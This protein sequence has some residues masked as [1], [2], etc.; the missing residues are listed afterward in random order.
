ME[1]IFIKQQECHTV[2]TRL[3]SVEAL[4]LPFVNSTTYGLNSTV[5]KSIAV[6]NE[7]L[8]TL[9]TPSLLSKSEFRLKVT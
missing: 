1:N 4:W 3:A 6:W 2:N 5:F 8:H 9:G 7:S